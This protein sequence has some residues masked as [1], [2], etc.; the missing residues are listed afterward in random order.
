MG[1]SH[2]LRGIIPVYVMCDPGDIHV[3]PQV[4]ATHNDL[5]TIFV[6]DHYPGGIGLSKYMYEHSATIMEATID[7]IEACPCVSG[8]P[9]CVGTE[10]GGDSMK[11][12]A[13][14]ILSILVDRYAEG[15]MKHV[16]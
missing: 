2:A 8:C 10:G 13:L 14:R 1:A 6:Y 15:V 12:D 4:K 5:P 7:A 3:Y 16:H 11:R 9:S